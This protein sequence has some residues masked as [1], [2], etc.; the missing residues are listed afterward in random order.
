MGKIKT[1]L[2]LVASLYLAQATFMM[3]IDGT[4]YQVGFLLSW[5]SFFSQLSFHQI[6]F[7]VVRFSF[8]CSLI[9][10]EAFQEQTTLYT[11]LWKAQRL[12]WV[13]S[14]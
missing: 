8:G 9:I 6:F 7:L 13:S 5:D 14:H 1:R 2:N 4:R 3:G 11:N 12:E 10:T